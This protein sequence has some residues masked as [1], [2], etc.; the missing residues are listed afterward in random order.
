[1]ASNPG[2]KSVDIG[3]ASFSTKY[4]AMASPSFP[5]SI[6]PGQIATLSI[7]FT[8]N[9]L[10]NPADFGIIDGVNSPIGLPQITITG[11]AL[12]FGGPTGFPQGRSDTTYVFSDTLNYLRGAH[13]FKL[14][15]E[16]RCRWNLEHRDR[17]RN[18]WQL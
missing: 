13:S 14:G 17:R 8:P 2:N 16:F 6:A 4:F 15:G 18:E 12:N 3:S 11:S 5:F 10:L 9:A 7:S 1:M